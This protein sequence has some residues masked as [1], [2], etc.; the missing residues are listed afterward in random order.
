MDNVFEL[1]QGQVTADLKEL[2]SNKFIQ[3]C[4]CDE[5]GFIKAEFLLSN[6]SGFEILVNESCLSILFDDCLLY[7]SPS[8]RD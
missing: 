4:L 1:L 3:S 2:E 5:K 6:E 7:T 8:P